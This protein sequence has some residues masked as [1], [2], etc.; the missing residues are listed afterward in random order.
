MVSL[1]ISQP[2]GILDEAFY[3]SWQGTS[4]VY[5]WNKSADTIGVMRS[6]SGNPRLYQEWEKIVRKWAD[7]YGKAVK[8]PKHYSEEELLALAQAKP[9]INNHDDE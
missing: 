5:V 3:K 4:F 2:D 6:F 1:S 9:S 7:D 8:A